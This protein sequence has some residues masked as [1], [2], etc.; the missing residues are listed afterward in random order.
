[1]VWVEM[2]C[3]K[4]CIVWGTCNATTMHTRPHQIVPNSSLFHSFNDFSFIRYFSLVF[5]QLW[6]FWPII[7]TTSFIQMTWCF[8]GMR[9]KVGEPRLHRVIFHFLLE[10]FLDLCRGSEWRRSIKYRAG[11]L[12]VMTP[13]IDWQLSWDRPGQAYYHFLR[14]RGRQ[15]SH[16]RWRQ[17]PILATTAP[18]ADGPQFSSWISITTSS[19]F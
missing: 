13:G 7:W 8:K 15:F 5:Q 10:A 3:R 18:T 19:N 11:S 14:R 6:K 2:H 12:G 16:H 1:M 4:H 9:W 17:A